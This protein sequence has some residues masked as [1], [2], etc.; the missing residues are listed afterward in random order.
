MGSHL[1]QVSMAADSVLPRDYLV[2][3]FT[4]NDVVPGSD[5]GQLA[6]DAIGVFQQWTGVNREIR[7]RVYD[8]TSPPPNFPVADKVVNAGVAPVS[9]VPREIA[10][11]LSFYADRNVP[12]QRGRIYLPWC[13]KSGVTATPLR[14][15]AATRT[16]ALG[17][18]DGLAA[19]GGVDIDWQVWSET[20]GVGRKVTNAWVD[21]EWDTQ[22]RRGLR[23]TTRAAKAVG[24]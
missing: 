9:Q 10:V 22:R 19:L 15:D 5:W 20:E 3:T 24:A 12:R 14:P 21:D 16:A 17:I 18:A 8:R 13:A 23:P 7:C 11:C 1:F 6:S 4:L 2:N